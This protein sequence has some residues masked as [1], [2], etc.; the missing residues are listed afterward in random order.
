MA[1]SITGRSSRSDASVTFTPSGETIPVAPSTHIR[2]NRH[3]PTM[4]PTA[5]SR[6]PRNA[7][8]IDVASSGSDVPIATTVSPITSSLTPKCLAMSVAEPTRSCEPSTSTTN[9]ATTYRT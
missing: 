6:W 2:L 5:M 9:P 7:A 1:A 4:L 3:D 8:I